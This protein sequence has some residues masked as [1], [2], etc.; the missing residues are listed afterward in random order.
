M[1]ELTDQLTVIPPT[2]TRSSRDA[3]TITV[4][5]TEKDAHLVLSQRAYGAMEAPRHVVVLL[6]R[7]GI[8]LEPVATPHAHSRR[9]NKSGRTI[10][11]RDIAELFSVKPGEK[12]VLEATLDAGRLVADLP[13]AFYTRYQYKARKSA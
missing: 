7:K 3:I 13:G 6:S 10:Q 5:A 1:I 4:R 11:A 9:V 12:F 2:G 8:A